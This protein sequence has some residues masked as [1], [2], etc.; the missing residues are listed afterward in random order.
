M[1]QGRNKTADEMLREEKRKARNEAINSLLSDGDRK[2]EMARKSYD[3]MMKLSNQGKEKTK[4]S[5]DAFHRALERFSA[6]IDIYKKAVEMDRGKMSSKIKLGESYLELGKLYQSVEQLQ[7]ASDTFKLAVEQLQVA[8]K[9]LQLP[10]NQ[11]PDS[12]NVVETRLG[13]AKK[14]QEQTETALKDRKGDKHDA[15]GA[16]MEYKNRLGS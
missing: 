12:K 2:M 6:A 5:N 14:L 13:E 15:P 1:S 16:S 8:N 7:N 3:V 10:F 4:D 9:S 11:N